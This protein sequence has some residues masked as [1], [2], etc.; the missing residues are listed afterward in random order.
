IITNRWFILYMDKLLACFAVMMVSMS[1]G[2]SQRIV[3][4]IYFDTQFDNREYNSEF[5]Q[6]TSFV[7]GIS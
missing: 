2:Y 6:N 7:T 5:S 4:D 1:K 3:W